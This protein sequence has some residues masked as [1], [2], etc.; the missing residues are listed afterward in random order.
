METGDVEHLHVAEHR[1]PDPPHAPSVRKPPDGRNDNILTNPAND[2]RP[3]AALIREGH[4]GHGA[5]SITPA[6]TWRSAAAFTTASARRSSRFPQLE[7]WRLPI[8]KIV[9]YSP[10]VLVRLPGWL[11]YQKRD[12]DAGNSSLY[13]HASVR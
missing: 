1:D 4:R 10:A 8:G 12:V 2:V 13:S 5:R 9:A 7:R 6:A 11:V 3:R